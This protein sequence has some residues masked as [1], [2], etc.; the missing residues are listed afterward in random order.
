MSIDRFKGMPKEILLGMLEDFAKNWLAH[1][2]LWFQAVEKENDME[3]AIKLD[4]EAWER[5]TQIEAKRI[6]SR[7][8]ADWKRSKKRSV[9]DCIPF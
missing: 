3:V 7:A 9:L 5:F 4:T 2:G 8:T 1:D 6:I